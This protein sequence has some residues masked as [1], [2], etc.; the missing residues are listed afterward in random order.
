MAGDGCSAGQDLPFHAFD[1]DL[2]EPAAR[3]AQS[4]DGDDVDRLRRFAGSKRDAAEIIARPCN[5][6]PAL[7]A[8]PRSRPGSRQRAGAHIDDAVEGEV[9]A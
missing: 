9:G 1:I 2:D 5:R 6:G 8:R 7:L 4:V 3:K